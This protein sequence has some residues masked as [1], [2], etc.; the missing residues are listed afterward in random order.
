M[1]A[2]GEKPV[3]KFSLHTVD[4]VLDIDYVREKPSVFLGS[5]NKA[6]VVSADLLDRLLLRYLGSLLRSGRRLG[7]SQ[8][9]FRGKVHMF[10]PL[11]I[12]TVGLCAAVAPGPKLRPLRLY[13]NREWKTHVVFSL[14][15]V[16][17]L[18]DFMQRR[19]ALV[20]RV[21][22]HISFHGELA[23]N[24]GLHSAVVPGSAHKPGEHAQ[25][26]ALPWAHMP[27]VLLKRV[28]DADARFTW[29][30]SSY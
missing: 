4:R 8:G 12:D 10:P 24:A 28:F 23:L 26:Y 16:L 29:P 19:A 2:A 15:I 9:C 6:R 11:F 27:G 22:L 7:N 21:R 14:L 1:A 13:L 5:R 17:S 30:E 18:L 20:R 3:E 25:E